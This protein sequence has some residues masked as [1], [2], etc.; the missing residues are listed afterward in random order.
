L[1]GWTKPSL[2]SIHRWC[3]EAVGEIVDPMKQEA[4][5]TMQL[6]RYNQLLAASMPLAATGAPVMIQTVLGIMDRMN[7]LLKI[8]EAVE[9]EGAKGI[10]EIRV[11]IAGL[12]AKL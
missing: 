4:L 1:P 6:S 8:G 9:D 3:E 12:D 2:A 10:K 7:K 11:V 5:L